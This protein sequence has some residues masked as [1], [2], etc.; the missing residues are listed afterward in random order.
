VSAKLASPATETD[1]RI[2]CAEV[3]GAVGHAN[4][5]A[6]QAVLNQQGAHMQS[7]TAA[8]NARHALKA[9]ILTCQST[10]AYLLYDKIS[11]QQAAVSFLHPPIF[12]LHQVASCTSCCRT[13]HC[14]IV[15]NGTAYCITK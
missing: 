14:A 2:T 5:E 11:K 9:S 7:F 4:P 12:I 13:C 10:F 15:L 1:L 3:L 8:M 6:A